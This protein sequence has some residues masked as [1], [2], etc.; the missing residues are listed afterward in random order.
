VSPF[1]PSSVPPPVVHPTNHRFS[2]SLFSAPSELLFSQLPCFHNHLRCPLLFSLWRT[3]RTSPTSVSPCLC[4]KSCP[5]SGLPPLVLSCRSFSHA[6]PLF[7]TVCSLFC[8]NTGGGVSA[9]KS[10]RTQKTRAPF[11]V[12]RIRLRSPNG[13]M[14]R[15]DGPLPGATWTPPTHPS[16]IASR[17]R[18]PG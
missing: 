14:P 13:F 15:S 11:R 18:F 16:I 10:T 8:Q 1:D 5:F 12:F 4:G 3:T 2:T 17:S 9:Y 7:S 6:S